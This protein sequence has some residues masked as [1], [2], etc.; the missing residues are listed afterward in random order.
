MDFFSQWYWNNISWYN[1]HSQT[2][3][4]PEEEK[5]VVTTETEAAPTESTGPTVNIH[6]TEAAKPKPV[7]KTAKL[8]VNT[9][10]TERAEGELDC[11]VV[12]HRAVGDDSSVILP[13]DCGNSEKSVILG[14]ASSFELVQQCASVP[15]KSEMPPLATNLGLDES[16]SD[17]SSLLESAV[18]NIAAENG[19]KQVI[20]EEGEGADVVGEVL[21]SENENYDFLAVAPA[22]DCKKEDNW[23]STEKEE[24][25]KEESAESFLEVLDVELT[26]LKHNRK[27]KEVDS[28]RVQFSNEV[29]YF[30]EEQLPMTLEDGIEAFDEEIDQRSPAEDE[31]KG[32]FS[33]IIK[34]LPVEMEKY[35]SVQED[36]SEEINAKGE[37]HNKY[38]E[39]VL[40]M[41]LQEDFV[42]KKV[43]KGKECVMILEEEE[44]IQ[45]E[46]LEKVK[47]KEQHQKSSPQELILPEA[48]TS[49]TFLHSPPTVSQ[50]EVSAPVALAL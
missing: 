36:S 5:A 39:E 40:N 49:N 48:N 34:P 35:H 16:L 42:D 30:K 33:D 44:V 4:D 8:T 15:S 37:A 10:S 29:K 25:N 24:H 1:Y 20:N 27:Q 26:N 47:N 18:L 19:N 14:F 9:V 32:N 17:S 28:K 6:I 31:G 3:A 50:P 21:V 12:L 23:S 41:K 38:N 2:S 11:V 13:A 45:A 7:Y 43:F 22:G 46:V